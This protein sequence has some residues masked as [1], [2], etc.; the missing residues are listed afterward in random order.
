MVEKFT[1]EVGEHTLSFETG[2]LAKQA[3]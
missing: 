2:K 3:N 1:I